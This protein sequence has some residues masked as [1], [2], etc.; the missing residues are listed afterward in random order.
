[1]NF[2]LSQGQQEIIRRAGEFAERHVAPRAAAIDR[3]GEF[4]RDLFQAAA[5][6]GLAGLNVPVAYGGGG[7][8]VLACVGAI[9]EVSR[10]CASSGAILLVHNLL[11]CE[12]V[13]TVASEHQRNA[14]LRKLASGEWLGAFAL[15][16]SEAGSDFS[17]LQTTAVRAASGY[18]LSGAKTWVTNGISADAFVVF[19][20][21][22]DA[23]LSAFL[24]E[25]TRDGV[26]VGTR[27]ESLGVC[28][29]GCCEV[30]FDGCE[31]PAENRL[32]AEG[33][34]IRI[35]TRAL[36]TGRIGVAAQ[37]IGIGRAC[38]EEAL[39]YARTRQQG[40]Q[41]IG[42]F[43][44][45]QWML[46]DMATEI[47][48]ARL[49]TWKAA[50]ARDQGLACTL[51]SAVAKLAASEAAVRASGKGMQV[52]GSRGY[53]RQHSMERFFR[54]SKVTE[55]DLGASDIQRLTIAAQIL[56]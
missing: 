3:T 33:D 39:D 53:S 51:E 12:A 46:A 48:A 6:A 43:Q 44:A 5:A 23:A 37:A 17:S 19:A 56:A 14:V 36:D 45:V 24:V 54:D 28:G 52:L 27:T 11:V 32:G 25:R 34:G 40:G 30:V 9:E 49:L 55:I 4:P 21:T 13:S 2:D 35:A 16:E 50:S 8:G 41:A 20:K 38:L 15:A 47:D 31:V 7:Q 22:G 10:H 1:M 18:R 29:S 42:E 26:R